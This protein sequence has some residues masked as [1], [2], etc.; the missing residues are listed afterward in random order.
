MAN[1]HSPAYFR[2]RSNTLITTDIVNQWS[3]SSFL[4]IQKG[5]SRQNVSFQQYDLSLSF[6]RA[7]ARAWPKA[8]MAEL[9]LTLVGNLG[10][11]L[12]HR[13]QPSLNFLN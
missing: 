1:R 13:V 4:P 7:L 9:Q 11:T 2:R 12:L 10:F 5:M 8:L 6:D 3:R